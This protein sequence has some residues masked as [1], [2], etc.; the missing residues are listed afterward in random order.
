MEVHE[1]DKNESAKSNSDQMNKKHTHLV[2]INITSELGTI[3]SNLPSEGEII[4]SK[5]QGFNL[6][7]EKSPSLSINFFLYWNNYAN[8]K[9]QKDGGG[10]IFTNLKRIDKI[11][12]KQYHFY[13]KDQRKG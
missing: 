11:D 8:I 9:K 7:N 2:Q 3:S 12:D 4:H 13:S 5:S 10:K 1:L 6:N